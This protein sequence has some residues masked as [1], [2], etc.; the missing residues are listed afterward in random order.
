MFDVGYWMLGVGC[1]VLGVGCFLTGP[2]ASRTSA[3]S[4]PESPRA[5]I[6]REKIARSIHLKLVPE[7]HTQFLG[8]SGAIESH[9]G[10]FRSSSRTFLSDGKIQ[11]CAAL[12]RLTVQ[13]CG[14]QRY[15]GPLSPGKRGTQGPVHVAAEAAY[16]HS[17]CIN[18][19]RLVCQ[20]TASPRPRDFPIH[21]PS[22]TLVSARES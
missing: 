4:K 13:P 8:R 17:I 5:V 15:S 12:Y 1:W 10:S 6:L 3:S 14:I 7:F 2:S 11:P 21:Q 16:L 9:Y 19:R 20:K 18:V 22:L